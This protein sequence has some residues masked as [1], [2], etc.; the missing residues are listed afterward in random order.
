MA[1]PFL[2]K[3]FQDVGCLVFCEK[4]QEVY[5]NVYLTGIFA[6]SFRRDKAIIVGVEFTILVEDISI[7]TGI[8]NHGEVWFKGMDLD[9]EN[10]EAF[11]KPPYKTTPKHIFPFKHLLDKYA[12]FMKMIMNYFTYEARF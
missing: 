9:V 12:P 7:A 6:T 4:I 2:K 10:Y 3:S 8:L 1:S 11:F 5:F